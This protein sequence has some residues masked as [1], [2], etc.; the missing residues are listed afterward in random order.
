MRFKVSYLAQ[1][2]HISD[3]EKG[4]TAGLQ[5]NNLEISCINIL[6]RARLLF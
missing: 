4:K 3:G 2:H 6:Y 5:S 1:N